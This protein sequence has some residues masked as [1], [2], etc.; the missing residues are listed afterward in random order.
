MRFADM[1]G[2]ARIALAACACA[3][4]VACAADAVPAPELCPSGR[5]GNSDIPVALASRN[6]T[7][8]YI[9]SDG[10]DAN[11]CNG[12]ADAAYSGHGT[13]QACAWK[14]PSIALPHSGPARIEGGDILRIA[15]GTYPIGED[16]YLQP[17]PSGPSKDAP[18][19]ILGKAGAMPKLVG[20]NGVHRVLNLDG[21]SNVELG[22]LEIT[23]RSDCVYKHSNAGAACTDAM[24]WA[25]VGLYAR[26]SNNVWLHDLN[27]HGMAA[28][29][30]NAGDLS[31]W[32]LERVKLNRN[33]TAGWD[34]NIEGGGSN[35]GRMIMRNIEIAWNGCGERV[36]TGEPWACWAQK[37]GGY[38]DGL[39]TTKTGGQWLIEDAYVHHNTSD[40][41]DLRYM[42]G[43]DATRVTLRRIR[44]IANAGNQVKVKGNSLIENSVMVG[45]CSFFRNKFFMTDGDLC[46]SDGSTLQLVMT[47]HNTAIVRRNTLSGE[48]AVQIGHSEGDTS[49]RID[50][51]NNLVIGYPRYGDPIRLS[52][53]DG[54]KSKAAI[55][56]SGNMAWKV[57]ACPGDTL[58]TQDPKLAN[59]ALGAFDAKPLAGSPANGK[60]GAVTCGK[61]APR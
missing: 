15:S 38:G 54:G 28:R 39:G 11:Q 43:A 45:S 4:M 31:N 41:L 23:D 24:P 3:A 47:G 19:R 30:I 35:S 8:Y 46:R 34:G 42:D 29:G 51:R 52:A 27:I 60:A 25:R 59:M 33:G 44:A 10:G 61:A 20:V 21:S 18:T 12:R 14:N 32:T 17:V 49:D 48:G 53:F 36:A 1:H 13:A 5:S 2:G 6:A 55:S 16:D 57:A 56:Y 40:G 50:I 37:T 7:T 9:R 26:A 58:C 22:H